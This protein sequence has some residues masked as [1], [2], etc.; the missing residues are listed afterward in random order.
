VYQISG[1]TP[2]AVQAGVADSV[3][4][5]D[6]LTAQARKARRVAWVT[7]P[8]VFVVI[9]TIAFTLRGKTDSG[10]SVFHVEDQIA[11]TAL[12]LLA[13]IAV[14]WFT[15]PR[16]VAGAD[17]LRV[18]NLLGWIDIPWELVSAVRFDRGSPWASLELVDDDLI[19]MMAVQAND[20]QYAIDTVRAL[21]ALLTEHKGRTAAPAE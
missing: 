1:V 17:G 11:M 19:A 3:L 20:K 2:A 9:A 14:L 18:R 16:V 13:A 7:A 6:T 5:T 8:V 15:R 12:G 21:R 4:V 10:K